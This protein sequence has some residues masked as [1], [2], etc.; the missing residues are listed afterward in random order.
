M[1]ERVRPVRLISLVL[2]VLAACVVLDKFLPPDAVAE[3]APTTS[4][5][6]RLKELEARVTELTKQLES[7]TRRVE[8]LPRRPTEAE[9]KKIEHTLTLKYLSYLES[10]R[11]A[12]RLYRV[13]A[14]GGDAAIEAMVR[15]KTLQAEAELAI[16]QGAL[17]HAV[18]TQKQA[19]MA[20]LQ[21][22]TSVQAAYETGTANYVDVMA[23]FEA[24]A[25]ATI[26]LW[27]LQARVDAGEPSQEYRKPDVG[28]GPL[29]QDGQRE[30]S[31]KLAAPPI[32]PPTR[33]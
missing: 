33:E 2:A 27:E 13:G 8:N 12:N 1:N 20:A 29:P 9:A 31:E 7:T 5:E 18:T 3:D 26:K 32:V 22:A 15:Y 24:R 25:D 11:Q 19:V 30:F 21:Q 23:A 17:E 14:R 10:W 28:D 16:A 6:R 4:V